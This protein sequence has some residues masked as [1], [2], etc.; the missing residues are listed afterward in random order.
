[1][2]AGRCRRQLVETDVRGERLEPRPVTHP[3]HTLGASST[4]TAIWIRSRSIPATR[5]TAV[6]RSRH[7][8]PA[9]P[10]AGARPPTADDTPERAM[11]RPGD[12]Q[13]VAA[14]GRRGGSAAPAGPQFAEGECGVDD[15]VEADV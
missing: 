12:G 10:P 1:M 6:Q 9:H 11:E 14:V 3:W 7:G 2:R 4:T 8:R 5:F 13:H 15:R